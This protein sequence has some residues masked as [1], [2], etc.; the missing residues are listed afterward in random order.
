MKHSRN[1]F[2]CRQRGCQDRYS[3]GYQ[4]SLPLRRVHE[5]KRM[6]LAS[7]THG[8]FITYVN[9]FFYQLHSHDYYDT[10]TQITMLSLW[11]SLLLFPLLVFPCQF[12]PSLKSLLLTWNPSS[13]VVRSRPPWSQVARELASPSPFPPHSNFLGFPQINCAPY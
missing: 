7:L 10:R 8:L 2:F 5:I 4:C 3:V 11:R 1:E 12:L 13:C 6:C 9:T